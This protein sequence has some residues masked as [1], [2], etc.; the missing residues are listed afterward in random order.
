MTRGQKTLFYLGFTLSIASGGTLAVMVYLIRPSDPF[1]VVNH[2]LQPLVQHLHILF[3]PILVFAMGWI[4][5]GHVL[6]N[7][8]KK[9]RRARISGWA[10]ALLFP[11]M[12]ISGYCFQISA[13]EPWP[14]I[15]RW[16][17]LGSGL[18]WTMATA[19]HVPWPLRKKPAL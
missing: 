15:W 8:H 13:T 12:A 18:L 9:I 6:N 16:L 4:W 2:P 5:Q 19:L 7:I 1:A 14:S 17:H 3:G 10:C 11:V